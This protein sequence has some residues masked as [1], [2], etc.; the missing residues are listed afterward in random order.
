MIAV[1]PGLR[2]WRGLELLEIALTQPFLYSSS[3]P[4]G[5]ERIGTPKKKGEFVLFKVA[6]GLRA[7]RGLEQG[8]YFARSRAAAVAPGLRAWRGL[9]QTRPTCCALDGR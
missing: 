7:W 4:S 8:S 5:L 2:A 6:P 1:A 9:E 3:G